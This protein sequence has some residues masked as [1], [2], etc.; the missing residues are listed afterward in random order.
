MTAQYLAL[1]ILVAATLNHRNCFVRAAGT[2]LVAVGLAF[3]VASVY[4]ADT[5]ARLGA[6]RQGAF[7]RSCSMYKRRLRSW[8]SLFCCGLPGA[9]CVVR[10]RQTCHGAIRPPPMG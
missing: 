1:A 3:I 8:Q 10:G 7:A 6:Y 4:L 5:D 2:L 9:S